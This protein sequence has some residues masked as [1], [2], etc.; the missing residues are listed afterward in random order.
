MR[1]PLFVFPHLDCSS[2][3][4]STSSDIYL[5]L[6]PGSWLYNLLWA[7]RSLKLCEPRNSIGIAWKAPAGI[8]AKYRWTHMP[9]CHHEQIQHQEW[10]LFF[11]FGSSWLRNFLRETLSL[12][13]ELKLSRRFG[14]LPLTNSLD[15]ALGRISCGPIPYHSKVLINESFLQFL[16]CLTVP[17]ACLSVVFLH[18]TRNSASKLLWST[19]LILCVSQT[20][21]IFGVVSWRGLQY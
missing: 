7:G 15:M 13:S 20:C 3:N 21:D 9:V 10:A 17:P 14:P 19:A 11:F 12:L 1:L 4:K 8:K 5:F 2:S 6:P 16:F 18:F